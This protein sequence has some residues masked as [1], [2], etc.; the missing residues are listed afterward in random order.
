[1]SRAH[2]FQHVNTSGVV[3]FEGE[4][5]RNIDSVEAGSKMDGRLFSGAAH[6]GGG[7]GGFL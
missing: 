1:M 6:R 3:L 7:E 5:Y 2:D 4:N